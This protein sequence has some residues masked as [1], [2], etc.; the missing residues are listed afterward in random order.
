MGFQEGDLTANGLIITWVYGSCQTVCRCTCGKEEKVEYKK[1]CGGLREKDLAALGWSEKDG[2]WTC[3][4]CV[5]KN[6]ADSQARKM[7]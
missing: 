2:Q 6:A 1:L 3:P 4:P 7:G 5:K